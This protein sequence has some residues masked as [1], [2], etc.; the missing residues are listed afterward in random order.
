[1][2]ELGGVPPAL[3]VIEAALFTISS[4]PQLD[5]L[6]T[7]SVDNLNLC[8]GDSA[9]SNSASGEAALDLIFLVEIELFSCCISGEIEDLVRLILRSLSINSDNCV[10][11][12]DCE[13]LVADVAVELDA[14][15][16]DDRGG[17]F[18]FIIAGV[19]AVIP[20]LGGRGGVLGDC[21]LVG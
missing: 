1:M 2:V 16:E 4:P 8:L 15:G 12:V 19:A 7:V 18:E 11:V 17:K 6:S 14:D 21:G 5:A 3:L 10:D 20:I 9:A 13:L